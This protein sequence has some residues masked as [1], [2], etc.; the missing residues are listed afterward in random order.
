MFALTEPL[1]DALSL[2]KVLEFDILMFGIPGAP[3]AAD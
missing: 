2:P 1:G 3:K